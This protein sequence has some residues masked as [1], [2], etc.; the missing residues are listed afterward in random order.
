MASEAP[1]PSSPNALLTYQDVL[2][3]EGISIRSLHRRVSEGSYKAVLAPA[4]LGNGQRERRIPLWCL[5]SRARARFTAL[6]NPPREA[7]NREGGQPR[8]GAEAKPAPF[9]PPS[10]YPSIPIRPDGLPDLAAMREFGM[11]RHAQEYERRSA[12][13]AEARSRLSRTR[14]TKRTK[15]QVWAE[16][17]GLY[18]TKARTLQRWDQTLRDAGP[19]A[20]VPTWGLALRRR[21]RSIPEELQ[22]KILEAW[23]DYTCRTARQIYRTIV[24]PWCQHM[25]TDPPCY[26]T[27]CVFLDRETRPI[28][29]AAFRKGPR[30]F[31]ANFAAKVVRDIESAEINQV[32]CA[33][34]RLMD[35][36]VLLEG[37]PKRPWVTMIADVR[38]AGFVGYRLSVMPC[39]ATVAHA[40]RSAILSVGVPGVFYRDNGREFTAKRVGGKPA[41]LRKPTKKDLGEHTRWP[42]TLPAE[43]EGGD[44]WGALGVEVR[45][46]LPYHAWSKPIESFFGALSRMFENLIPG[47]T[48]RDAKQK[49]EVLAKH[50]AEGKLLTWEQFEEVFGRIVAEWNTGHCCG[51]R[52]E[53]PAAAY[54]RHEA[55]IPDARA[56]DVLLQDVR[57]VK[58][59]PHGIKLDGRLYHCEQLGPWVG[60]SVTVRRD[61]GEPEWITV[62][63]PDAEV[64]AV[65]EIPKADHRGFGPANE[66]AKRVERAQRVYLTDT[67]KERTGF[68]TE[69]ELDPTG[70]FRMV[71]E[72]LATEVTL[73][74][75]QGKQLEAAAG[76]A[77]RQLEA[78]ERAAEDTEDE[79]RKAL[80]ARGRRLVK[81]REERRGL[82]A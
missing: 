73:R 68:C 41:R 40:V 5:S 20:L 31:K 55:R 11:A 33:D 67:R 37:K 34:H 39:A 62:Y 38:T 35:V 7:E 30:A 17:A 22:G 15:G 80:R 69:A 77:E 50:L 29:D 60:A 78:R 81:E 24:V 56:L 47:Y 4:R 66:V 18:N 65:R 44:L 53:T 61:P 23:S 72:R 49:P 10:P 6:D 14:T 13:V 9:A 59:R 79:G 74:Q 27:V 8:T 57:E 45:T 51:E 28:E 21:Y 46:S 48:G 63:T 19:V 12:A 1:C 16:V 32:W 64:L 42:A 52:T 25:G 36:M 54:E 76:E 58:V 75:A 2:R 26:R 82:S 3:L 70:A 71:Q 43:L